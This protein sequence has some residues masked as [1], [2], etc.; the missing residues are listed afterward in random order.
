MKIRKLAATSVLAI[1]AMGI[2][3]GSAYA[4]PMSP[5][6]QTDILPGIH[7]KA[8]V[9]DKSVVLTTDSGSLTTQGTQFQVL[10][11][12]GNLVA[13]LPLTYRKDG[14]EWPMAAKIEGNKATITPSTDAKRTVAKPDLKPVDAQADFNAALSTAS[15]QIGLAMAVGA[16]IGTIVGSVIGCVAGFIALVG[17]APVFLPGPIGGCLAGI[18]IGA[19]IG[20]A[21]GTIVIG[22]PV[23]IISAI[24]FGQ[25]VGALPK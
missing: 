12:K 17:I 4:A 25:A 3:A 9:V 5:N 7:Y 2:T 6:V 18:G 14:K 15:T 8:S 10:D 11:T 24:Q 22:T 16:L 19:T 21:V 13:G 20:I 1:A 23:A